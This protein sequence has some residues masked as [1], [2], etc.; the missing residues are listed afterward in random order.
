VLEQLYSPLVVVGGALLDEVRDIAT[1]C[2]TRH[3]VHHYLGFAR[4]QWQLVCKDDPPRLK[5]LLY[6]YRVLLTGIHLMRTGAIEAN[7]PRL[8][9]EYPILGLDELIARKTA[10]EENAT[11]P[12]RE[13]ERHETSVQEWTARLAE[14]GRATRLRDAP[15]SRRALSDFLVR[16]RLDARLSETR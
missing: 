10:G 9:A 4:N 14:A 16:L 12:P 11:V 3:H 13:L 6:V 2:I 1:G 8:N 5:P 15:E 7:L